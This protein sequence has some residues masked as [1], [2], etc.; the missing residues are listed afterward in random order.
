LAAVLLLV[1]VASL[2][3]AC[4]AKRQ[5]KAMVLKRQTVIVNPADCSVKPTKIPVHKTKGEF[6]IWRLVGSTTD[7]YEIKFDKG[8]P[9]PCDSKQDPPPLNGSG[10]ETA[11]T[12]QNAHYMEYH[13]SVSKNGTK[14]MPDPSVEV[15][16]GG[17]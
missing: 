5:V 2:M 10:D 17:C 16:N 1:M 3:V 13:Y 14:C 7:E 8:N 4:A 9:S 11:C 12:V 15:C 6:V